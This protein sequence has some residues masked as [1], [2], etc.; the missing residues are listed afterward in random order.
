MTKHYRSID[1]TYDGGKPC[2]VHIYRLPNVM[3]YAVHGTT[4]VMATDQHISVPA[5]LVVDGLSTDHFLA[6]EPIDTAATL[7]DEVEKWLEGLRREAEEDDHD[8]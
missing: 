1:G 6:D 8:H 4:L 2:T 7:V 3:W 5:C